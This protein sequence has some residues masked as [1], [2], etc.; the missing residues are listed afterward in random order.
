MQTTFINLP[1]SQEQNLKQAITGIAADIDPE[2]IICYGTR[3]WLDN[4]WSGFDPVLASNISTDFDLL[5]ITKPGQK[6]KDHEVLDRVAGYITQ[7]TRIVAIVHS[8]Y[9]VTEALE[10]GRP[11][12]STVYKHGILVYDSSGIP[13]TIPR[14]T[15]KLDHQMEIESY[16][17]HHFGL[18][19]KFFDGASYY[20]TSGSAALAVFMLHQATEHACM[21]LIKACLGYRP[22]T[23]NLSR[24]L[25][26]TE[27]FSALPSYLFPQTSDEE[28]E[29]FK[30]LLRAYSDVRY[31]ENFK[32]PIEKAEI[33]RKRVKE[34]QEIA[35]DLYEKKVKPTSQTTAQTIISH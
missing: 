3:T 32:M 21:A 20:I 2:K 6:L 8:L 29:L 23:H 4:T 31:T 22:T 19:T 33:L 18:S 24:L 28:E 34:L 7:E 12:F 13:L 11:F 16:C 1:S 14:P 9:A 5:I 30:T 17:D 27:N 15:D 25:A 26:L 10:Q 35:I